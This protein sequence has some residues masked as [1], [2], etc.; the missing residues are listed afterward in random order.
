MNWKFWKS[1]DQNNGP[2]ITSADG[3]FAVAKLA[4]KTIEQNEYDAASA[5]F[6]SLVRRIEAAAAQGQLRI[7][8]ADYHEEITFKTAGGL[9]LLQEH[10]LAH[11][12][13]YP[14]NYLSWE[15]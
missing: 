6:L 12:S 5:A 10:G 7:Y 9:R 15:R 11:G 14:C 13:G 1:A 8:F 4:K 3:W 2:R